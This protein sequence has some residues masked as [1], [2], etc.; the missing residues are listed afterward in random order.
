VTLTRG[1]WLSAY[2]V[3]QDHW[4]AV[5]GHDL[6]GHVGPDLPVENVSWEDCGEFCRR[7]AAEE[8]QHYRLPT[9]AEWEYACRAGTP[10]PF[11]WGATLATDLANYNGE[12]VY[13]PGT[14]GVW[15]RRPVPVWEFPPNAWGLYQMH[16]NVWEWCADFLAPYPESPQT[17]PTGP[18]AGEER[19]LR[20]GAWYVHPNRCRSSFRV[21]YSSSSRADVFGC[22]LVVEPGPDGWP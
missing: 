17:D 4:R 12:L 14:Q 16:G 10:T 18:T 13:G 19:V 8:G 9:E 21:G 2:A 22:R 1:F 6:S 20:G 3:T 5:I 11:F 15:R 7:L